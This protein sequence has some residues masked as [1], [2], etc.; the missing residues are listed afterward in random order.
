MLKICLVKNNRLSPIAALGWV[1]NKHNMQIFNKTKLRK[2][3]AKGL[4]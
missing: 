4:R 3:K 1:N 2:Q